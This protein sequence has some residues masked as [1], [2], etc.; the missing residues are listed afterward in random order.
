MRNV[1]ADSRLISSMCLLQE[2]NCRAMLDELSTLSDYIRTMRT[3]Y[4]PQMNGERYYTTE[5][6]CQM[7]KITKRTLQQYRAT[8][9]RL[10]PCWARC[11]TESRTCVPH[12]RNTMS[13]HSPTATPKTSQR[14]T[15][16]DNILHTA[17]KRELARALVFCFGLN[18]LFFLKMYDYSKIFHIF[19]TNYCE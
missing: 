12:W 7:L 15:V 14:S 6:V 8:L 13:P 2:T 18:A 5:E 17:S 16:D 4:K 10:S 11:S 19:M 9:F 3:H 1:N